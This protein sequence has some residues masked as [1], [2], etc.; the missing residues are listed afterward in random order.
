MPQAFFRAPDNPTE[1]Q[2]KIDYWF[3]GARRCRARRHYAAR[4]LLCC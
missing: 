4:R 3:V 2:S 1:E